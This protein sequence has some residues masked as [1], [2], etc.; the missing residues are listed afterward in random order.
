MRCERCDSPSDDLVELSNGDEVCETC[1]D[2]LAILPSSDLIYKHKE[3]TMNLKYEVIFTQ[4]F[5][6]VPSRSERATVVIAKL[7]S[8]DDCFVIQYNH[9]EGTNT[10]LSMA[11]FM[12]SLT[13]VDQ[14]DYPGI[15]AMIV[16]VSSIL[17]KNVKDL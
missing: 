5:T 13:Y 7:E 4:E 17:N 16:I 9:H 15:N 12:D 8:D 11:D 3:L 6:E 1:A 10:Y 14:A 2:D